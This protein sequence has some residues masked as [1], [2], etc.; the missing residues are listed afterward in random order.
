MH[1]GG[2]SCAI[3]TP[4]LPENARNASQNGSRDTLCSVYG[5]ELKASAIHHILNKFD[6]ID[7]THVAPQKL[8]DFG[9]FH[10]EAL[11]VT[12]INLTINVIPK[13]FDMK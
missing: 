11:G 7:S 2:Q 1:W 6:L 3:Y 5:V 4:P 13:R 12:V 10:C 8:L 9:G